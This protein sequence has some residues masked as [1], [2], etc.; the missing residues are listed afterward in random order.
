MMGRTDIAPQLIPLPEAH[1]KHPT[2]TAKPAS[3]LAS[4]EN[5]PPANSQIP[6]DWSAFPQPPKWFPSPRFALE[7]ID[8]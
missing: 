2:L 3:V 6:F 7:G 1:F 4:A 8:K 5:R